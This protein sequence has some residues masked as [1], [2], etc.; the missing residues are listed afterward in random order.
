MKMDTQGM[1]GEVSSQF[2]KA[3]RGE[4]QVTPIEVKQLKCF[5]DME[6]D[7]LKQIFREVLLEFV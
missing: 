5:T 4:F 7:E 6:R 2:S 3:N 1:T